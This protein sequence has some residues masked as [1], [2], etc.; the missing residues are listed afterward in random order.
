[1]LA[2]AVSVWVFSAFAGLGSLQAQPRIV[3]EV[4]GETIDLI[5]VL[6][7][8]RASSDEILYNI[9]LEQGTPV[10]LEVISDDIKRIYAMG[11]FD[12]IQV[13][14]D[15]IDGQLVITYYVIEKPAI[16]AIAFEGN[17]EFG[18][19][20]LLE[21]IDL[22]V[23]SILNEAK[24]KANEEKL[25]EHYLKEGFYLA[26]V[27]SSVN[28]RSDGDVEVLFRIRE[29][30]KVTV[31]QISILGNEAL[32]DDDIKAHIFTREA[33][34]LGFLSGAGEFKED[35]FK[36][37]MQ[38]IAA[39]YADNGYPDARVS[40]PQVSLSEDRRSMFITLRIEEGDPYTIS[41]VDISG[42][43]LFEKEEF[44]SALQLEAGQSFKL[45]T[46]FADIKTLRDRYADEGYAYVNVEPKRRR[47]V[48]AKT[49]ALT[50]DIVKGKQV[51]FGR[52]EVI[53]NQK[54]AD[55]VIRRELLIS[56]GA[57]YSGTALETSQR[58]VQRLGFFEKVD[59][60]THAA[61]DQRFLDVQVEVTERPTGT[62]QV[63]AGFSSIESF[64]AT[65][66]V[67][68]ENFLGFGTSL[69]AQASFSGLRQLFNIQYFDPYFLDTNWRVR[70]TG[71]KF[72]YIFSDFTRSSYGGN[73]GFGYPLLRDLILDLTYALEQVDVTPGGSLGRQKRNIGSLFQG[74]L[75]SSLGA[76]LAWDTRDNRLFPSSGFIQQI[77]VEIAD[78]LLVSENEF[79][80]VTA[81]S[82]WYF[83]L[84]FGLV[85]KFNLEAG[86]ISDW[87]ASG[88]PVPIFERFFVGGPN[89][90]R[91]FRRASLGPTRKVAADVDDPS[92]ALT[93]FNVGGD[94]Q[95]L[96][97]AEIEI[98]IL[99]SVGIKGVLFADAGNAFDNDQDIGFSLDLFS[100]QKDFAKVL[101]TAVGFGFRWLSPIGPLRFE[102]GFPL[103]PLSDEEDFVFEFS[104]GNSF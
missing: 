83:P 77:G 66:Q 57:I 4:D 100:E 46:L 35:E 89:S 30:S 71:F 93:K 104:I 63:G 24:V 8:R 99:T 64:I 37:D 80:R 1:M 88:V 20:D 103:A 95:F 44:L 65:I 12:D 98:P 73:I 36:K 61:R 84:F 78:D 90:V 54:T 26:E 101:R 55:K 21:K 33:S 69:T 96:F 16:A 86:L 94:K 7:N 13:D 92:S 59:I 60:R 47:D 32:S 79:T 68:Q 19:S 51:R 70:L 29:Y 81:R 76:T 58:M 6:G 45:S 91:G 72:D 87:N 11:F 28:P 85:M 75:S 52:I 3:P 82:R 39:F 40:D 10:Q 5:R 67:S 56:E 22:R 50:Y 49:I 15:R 41:E 2:V 31:R 27:S 97:N 14:A 102:W 23:P 48:E 53:G 38:R 25:R 42:D 9:K 43:L 62:F 74:G 18:E 17:D 34:L